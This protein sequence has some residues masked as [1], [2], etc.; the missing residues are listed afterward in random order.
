MIEAHWDA[1]EAYCHMENK[2]TLGFVEA[3][4]NNIRVLQRRASGYRDAEY[5]RL[6]ILACMLLL[7]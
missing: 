2:T 4:K 3:L 5:F 7:V 1:I 6:K